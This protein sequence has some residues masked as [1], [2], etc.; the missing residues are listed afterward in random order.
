MGATTR[1]IRPPAIRTA[2]FGRVFEETAYGLAGI[3]G[4]SRS[5]DANGQYIRVQARR[6]HE[7]GQDPAGRPRRRAPGRARRPDPVPDHSARSAV[8]PDRGLGED[9]VQARSSRARRRSRRTSARRSAPRRSRATTPSPM[10][11]AL[12][13]LYD[14]YIDEA[15]RLA[16]VDELR[17][18]GQKAAAQ[19]PRD[20]DRPALRRRS[21]L[22]RAA[23]WG[24]GLMATAI[25]KHL[26][27][28]V[29]VAA[30][31][32]VAPR[33]HRLHRPGAAPAD[34]GPRGEA[35]RA[36][37]RVRDRA[38]GRPRPGPDDPRRRR[39][40]RRRR[41][42]SR[43]RTASASS[44]SRSTASSCRSTATRRS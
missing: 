25:R 14:R 28:F 21:A 3:A 6:R 27:D 29:A 11:P 17:E 19:A 24:S 41:R 4:E 31:L 23:R 37:G 42:T 18:D 43:S 1:S 20:A 38:G 39:A 2:P 8:Q 16:E 9:P 5:G 34:P 13:S 10:A 30:L 12:R 32:V 15:G 40:G 44:P 33:G 26:R 35:V 7:H 22:A 36:Q